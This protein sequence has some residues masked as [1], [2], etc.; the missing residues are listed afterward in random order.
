[1]KRIVFTLLI[2]SLTLSL[3]SC[4]K[5]DKFS[6]AEL[7]LPLD[8]SFE[9]IED[10]N[11]DKTYTDG[12][13][14]VGIIRISFAACVKEGIPTTMNQTELASFWQKRTEREAEICKDNTTPYYTYGIGDYFYA[15]GFYTTPNAYFSVLFSCPYEEGETRISE[16]VKIMDG[17]TI[18]I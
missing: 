6:H 13:T 7:S 1:M 17:A 14:V 12:N 8:E 10:A 2:F 18:K 11:F 9:E 16:F 15:N 5:T 3:F 4:K